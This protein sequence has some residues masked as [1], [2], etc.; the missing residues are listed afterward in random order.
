MTG[1]EITA[2]SLITTA[3]GG[4][5]IGVMKAMASILGNGSKKRSV[6]PPTDHGPCNEAVDELAEAIR[7]DM[8]ERRDQH[9]DEMRAST[10]FREAFLRYIAREEGR[11][12]AMGRTG[13]YPVAG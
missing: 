9:R 12:E 13:E 5:V 10:E 4:L 8:R 7:E 11:R 3:V 1:A 2:V 6:P